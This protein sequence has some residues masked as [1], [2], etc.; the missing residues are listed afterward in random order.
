MALS[1]GE[2]RCPYHQQPRTGPERFASG[3]SVLAARKGLLFSVHCDRL[4]V[5]IGQPVA[6]YISKWGGCFRILPVG[7][8]SFCGYRNYS[9]ML[10]VTLEY[11]WLKLLS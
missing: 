4:L 9:I 5:A 6:I 10:T 1:A 7:L 8:Q 2:G 11:S 3:I